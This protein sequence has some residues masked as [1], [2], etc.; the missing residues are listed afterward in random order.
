MP[1]SELK[2][3]L[4]RCRRGTKE[5]DLVLG[6]FAKKRYASLDTELK[7]QFDRLLQIQDPLLAEWLCLDHEP[8]EE[9]RDIVHEILKQGGD[10]CS[11]KVSD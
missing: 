3:V 11:S 7:G 6:T 2:K 1:D 5:L 9:L 10:S 4:W 8:D